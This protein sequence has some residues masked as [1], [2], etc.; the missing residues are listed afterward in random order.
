VWKIKLEAALQ[1][2]ALNVTTEFAI[3]AVGPDKENQKGTIDAS[4]GR[5]RA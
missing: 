4:R 5:K 3:H 1:N 2:S